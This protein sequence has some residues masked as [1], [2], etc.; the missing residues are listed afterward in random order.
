VGAGEPFP[1][2]ASA[3]AKSSVR[4]PRGVLAQQYLGVNALDEAAKRLDQEIVM[5]RRVTEAGA[6]TRQDLSIL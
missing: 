3:F 4:L 6:K 1:R 2:T 5:R